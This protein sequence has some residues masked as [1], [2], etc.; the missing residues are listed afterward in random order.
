[1]QFGLIIY[2]GCRRHQEFRDGNQWLKA[3]S[4]QGDPGA[5]FNLGFNL[6]FI[7]GFM[8]NL[9]FMYDRAIGVPQDFPMARQWYKAAALGNNVDAQINLA[10]M[11]VKGYGV[12]VDLN[13][14][15]IWW[16]KLAAQGDPRGEFMLGGLYVNGQGGLEKDYSKAVALL[17]RA[18]SQGHVHARELIRVLNMNPS[19]GITVD[20]NAD[21]GDVS[22]LIGRKIKI[23]GLTKKPELNGLHG[24]VVK[25]MASTGRYEIDLTG[26]GHGRV[27]LKPE[28]FQP[29]FLPDTE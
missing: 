6:G 10:N 22:H 2:G 19:A 11:Y 3:A 28:S 1:M 12:P 20:F 8:F 23:L 5:Q 13:Q 9:G 16:E 26:V 15:R 24:Y 25:F 18:A 27:A 29:A 21:Y 14:A 7:L 17:Q 4:A